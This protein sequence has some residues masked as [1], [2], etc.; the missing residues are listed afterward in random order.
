MT[1]GCCR[2]RRLSEAPAALARTST[3]HLTKN[4]CV[5]LLL[6]VFCCCCC[7]KEKKTCRESCGKNLAFNKRCFCWVR[8]TFMP[9]H[10]SSTIDYKYK[11]WQKKRRKCFVS[12]CRFSSSSCQVGNSNSNI[13]VYTHVV[14]VVVVV[15]RFL[16]LSIFRAYP[17]SI[18]HTLPGCLFI[19][20]IQNNSA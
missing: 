9:R 1:S 12:S 15:L 5:F 2:S 20:N 13:Y 8:V 7:F 10:S 4:S 18:G 3:H 19:L 17:E 14:V 6:V 16:L 11:F